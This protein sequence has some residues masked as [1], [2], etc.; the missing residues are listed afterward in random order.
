METTT[1][2]E[3]DPYCEHRATICVYNPETNLRDL[4]AT[5]PAHHKMVRWVGFVFDNKVRYTHHI[6][7]VD[8]ENG[9]II[10]EIADTPEGESLRKMGRGFYQDLIFEYNTHCDEFICYPPGVRIRDEK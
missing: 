3:N 6:K 5:I 2:R 10:V 7:S 4:E 9:T 8:A 1:T